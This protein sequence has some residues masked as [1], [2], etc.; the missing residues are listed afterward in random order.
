MSYPNIR[1]LSLIFKELLKVYELNK[2]FLGGIGSFVLVI[3]VHNIIKMK[4]I[5]ND[6]NYYQQLLEIC[7]FM[8]DHFEPYKTL[9]S[10][11]V[12]TKLQINPKLEL[13]IEDPLDKVLLNTT[14]IR[15]INEIIQMFGQLKMLLTGVE[16]QLL[17]MNIE[18]RKKMKK[19]FFE[20]WNI[21][22]RPHE[23]TEDER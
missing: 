4:G 5:E 10:S 8:T 20:K 11:D 9:I 14:K 16:T 19:I 23:I 22:F 18:E 13:N 3:L 12:K 17:E 1:V 21:L 2:P 6:N 15:Q 7:N